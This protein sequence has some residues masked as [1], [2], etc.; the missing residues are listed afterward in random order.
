MRDMGWGAKIRLLVDSSVAKSIAFRTG[1][2]KLR[3]LE[4]QFLWLQEAVRA[5]KVVLSKVRGDVNPADILTKPKSL[6]E[7]KGMFS[8]PS[9]DWCDKGHANA[10]TCS[11]IDG[12]PSL[13][14]GGVGQWIPH[15][16]P[17]TDGTNQ[18]Q[19]ANQCY[20]NL[21]DTLMF[22]SSHLS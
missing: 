17:R 20:Q 16:E 12:R 5:K 10:I 8:F 9:V 14:R 22:G 3:H 13:P 21:S 4:I 18:F 1:L 2:G 19:G 6:D 7:M 15:P 11:C